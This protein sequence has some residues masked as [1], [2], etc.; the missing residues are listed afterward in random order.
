MCSDWTETRKLPGKPSI[1]QGTR[2]VR[3]DPPVGES[4]VMP[5]SRL[6]PERPLT[7]SALLPA[8]P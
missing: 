1:L 8:N 6:S 5:L 4:M 7:G 2:E 3:T